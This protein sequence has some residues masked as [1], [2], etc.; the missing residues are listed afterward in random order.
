[1]N[2]KKVRK[3]FSLLLFILLLVSLWKLRFPSSLTDIR[4]LLVGVAGTFLIFGSEFFYSSRKSK[5]IKFGKVRRWLQAHMFIGVIGP[6]MIIYHTRLEVA[7]FSGIALALTLIVGA[8]GFF[9]H[10]LYKRIPKTINGK[11]AARVKRLFKHW[12]VL[13]EPLT[14]TLFMTVIIHMSSVFYYGKMI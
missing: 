5:K 10:Y 12:K 3:I 13:H 7:G 6:I 1:M 9:G 8:S 14:I 2:D 11:E 4:G